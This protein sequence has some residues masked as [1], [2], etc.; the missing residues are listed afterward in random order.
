MKAAADEL[1]ITHSN[2]QVD[3]TATTPESLMVKRQAEL[4]EK[5]KQIAATNE[6]RMKALEQIKGR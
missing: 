5:I 2:A 3:R 6:A 1:K 4:T